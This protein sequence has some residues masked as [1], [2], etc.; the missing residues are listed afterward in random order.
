MWD[1]QHMKCQIKLVFT[2]SKQ[3]FYLEHVKRQKLDST[4]VIVVNCHLSSQKLKLNISLESI[5]STNLTLVKNSF[6][7]IIYSDPPTF[8]SSPR[9]L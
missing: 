1:A 9:C 3:L 5:Q 7:A 8:K 6:K 2:Y 4:A